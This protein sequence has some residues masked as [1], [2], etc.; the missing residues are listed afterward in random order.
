[1]IVIFEIIG[2]LMVLGLLVAG[3]NWARRNIII[4]GTE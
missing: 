2:A 1:M 4:K 3:A